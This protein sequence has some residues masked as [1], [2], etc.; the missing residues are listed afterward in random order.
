LG[1]TFKTT[2]QGTLLETDD[3]WF[4]PIDCLTGPDGSVFVVD[5]YDQ[6]ANHVIPEDTWDKSNGRIWKIVYRDTPPTEKLDLSQRSSD[7]LVA[8][9]SHANAW[10]RREARRI[11]SERRDSAVLP[12]LR[13]MLQTRQAG[14]ASLEALWALY[15]SGGWN[16]ELAIELLDHADAD[17]RAWTVR[18]IGDEQSP[19]SP[20]MAQRLTRMADQEPSAAVR[21][22]LA[23]TSKRLS[24]ADALPIVARLLRRSD[25]ATDTHIP[26]LLW[27]AVENKALSD[28]ERVLSLLADNVLWRLPLVRGTIVERLARRYL[29]ERNEAG[30]TACAR[31]MA[32]APDGAARQ[33]L[34]AALDQDFGG[35]PLETVPAPLDSLARELL[36]DHA[37][38]P[39]AVR[40]AMRLGSDE[41]YRRALATLADRAAPQSTRL[42]LI[43]AVGQAARPESTAALV[44][45]LDEPLESIQLAA[46]AALEHGDDPALAAEV[47]RR[48]GGWPAALRNRAVNM[49]CARPFWARS[50]VQGVA[51]GRVDAKEV[52]VDQLRQMLAHRDAELATAIEQRW[53]KIRQATPGEKQSYVPVIGR[54]LNEGTGDPRRG[55]ALFVKH[56]ATCHMLFGEGNKIGPDLTS[57][58]RKN[59][60]ALLMNILDPSGYVR[61]EYVA[62]TAALQDGRVLTGL[63]VESTAQQLTLVDAKNQ[64]TVLARDEIE[65][66]IPSSQSLMPERLLETL[67]PQELR[68]LFRYLQSSGPPVPAS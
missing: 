9:L 20:A 43:S 19:L 12:K 68:D 65:E 63:V 60:D 42:A 47:L 11:M 21:S 37:S 62:Q 25:D 18:L 54:L 57:A 66:L 28:S 38:N 22:Q 1:S 14:E 7:E 24:G 16:Q 15:V 2:Y 55:H 26:L 3:V 45:L 41:A 51:D 5:W 64:K 49:L 39:V 52:S 23:C 36:T 33:A 35:R 32:L 4:R 31:L 10:Q 29:A 13:A 53:G 8:L 59:R 27:W 6:R 46:V 50:L 30:Y 48:Y 67:A 58:D 40:L 56:C 17:V 44:R 34:V 61:P